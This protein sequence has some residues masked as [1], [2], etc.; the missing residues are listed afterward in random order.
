MS[1][2]A[3]DAKQYLENAVRLNPDAFESH[4]QLGRALV[5]QHDSTGAAAHFRKAA[6]SPDPQVRR[7]AME[8]L[9]AVGQ[10]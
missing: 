10:R 6:E 5:V 8:S 7:A 1:G 2:R 3:A 9:Q 4:L